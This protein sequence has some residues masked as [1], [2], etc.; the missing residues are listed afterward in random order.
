MSR[1]LSVIHVSRSNSE[2]SLSRYKS[3]ILVGNI[4]TLERVGKNQTLVGIIHGA[5]C[6]NQEQH[7]RV[8]RALY[9]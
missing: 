9:S 4:P 8:A 1:Y 3:E 7:K 6:F 2:S 5:R